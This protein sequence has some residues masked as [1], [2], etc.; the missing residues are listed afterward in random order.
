VIVGSSE[1]GYVVDI[2]RVIIF[3][4][5]ESSSRDFASSGS[6]VDLYRLGVRLIRAADLMSNE[7]QEYS[8]RI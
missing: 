2:S 7:S 8:S 4:S 6:D 3:H 1:D 5:C